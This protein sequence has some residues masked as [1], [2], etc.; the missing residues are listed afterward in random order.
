MSIDE[1]KT[2]KFL[3]AINK[4]AKEQRDKLNREAQMIREQEE[5]RIE[6]EILSD[7]Y[8]LIQ[9]EMAAMKIEISNECSKKEFAG[10]RQL[11]E[12]RMNI[13]EEVF[14]KAEQKLLEYSQSDK[15]KALLLNSVGK[16]AEISKNEGMTLYIK[17]EDEYLV[18]EIKESFPAKCNVELDNQIKIGGIRGYDKE[19]G[20]IIDETMDSKLVDQREW[21]TE[22]S[23]L[24][25]D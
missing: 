20:V 24:M 22:N 7:A 12:K 5:I 8:N 17:P 14:K 16:I 19:N 10:K 6:D 9:R 23:G 15:Y 18:S 1:T 3:E 4:Y 25:I 11:F 13:M 21:F 2:S